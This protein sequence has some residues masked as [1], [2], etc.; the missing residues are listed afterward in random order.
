M[1]EYTIT[2]KKNADIWKLYQRLKKAGVKDADLD[3]G[4]PKTDYVKKKRSVIHKGDRKIQKQ[5][6]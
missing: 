5:E 1:S 4:Y 3:K 2:F 6:V